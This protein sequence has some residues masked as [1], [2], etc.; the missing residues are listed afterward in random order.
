MSSTQSAPRS[1]R[2]RRSQEKSSAKSSAK[3]ETWEIEASLEVLL[4]RPIRKQDC[5]NSSTPG[6]RLNGR[7]RQKSGAK[8]A[9]ELVDRKVALSTER[10]DAIGR[11]ILRS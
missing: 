1:S 10:T 8:R 7:S 6:E 9:L 11:W 3:L 4:P 2:R 5:S